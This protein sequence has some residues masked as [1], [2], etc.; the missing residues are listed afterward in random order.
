MMDVPEP[1]DTEL[2]AFFDQY[3]KREPQPNFIGGLEL[4]SA[5][6][7]FAVP[8]K[9]EV[10]YLKAEYDKLL[11]KAETEVKD[12][13]IKDFYEKNKDPYFI[14]AG[15]VLSDTPAAKSDATD[16]KPATDAQPNDKKD[17]KSGPNPKQGSSNDSAKRSVFQLTAFQQDAKS[18]GAPTAAPTESA[19][20]A[21]SAAPAAEKP[22]EF[23]PLDDVKDEIRREI[24]KLKVN[25]DL[26][27]LVDKVEAELSTKYNN[28]M[29]GV[30]DAEVS[31]KE[32]PKP[33]E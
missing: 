19:P 16:S 1:T 4:P 27:K 12:E 9:V 13:E 5:S 31:H 6:P 25:D 33:P 2:T 11:A 17:G 22:K 20:T 10:Q 23:Q 24:A 14:K 21:T 32:P 30:L 7:G 18:G 29:G 3:K 8:R 15:S 28:Y 26:E